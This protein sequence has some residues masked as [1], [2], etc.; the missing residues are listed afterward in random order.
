[1][2]RVLSPD[3][4]Q[5]YLTDGR[6]AHL[7]AKRKRQAAQ[8]VPPPAADRA[9]SAEDELLCWP[10]MQL[11]LQQDLPGSHG[12]MPG[13]AP[14]MVTKDHSSF[15]KRLRSKVRLPTHQALLS[16]VFQQPICMIPTQFPQQQHY[17]LL[18]NQPHLYAGRGVLVE[19]RSR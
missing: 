7:Q 14:A 6:M 11:A 9:A 8:A 12:L 5:G 18:S 19:L 3:E 16:A 1:M 17:A 2:A 10:S 13:A 4:M 15:L